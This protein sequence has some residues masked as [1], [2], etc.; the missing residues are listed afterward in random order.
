MQIFNVRVKVAKV[1]FE[2]PKLV[3]YWLVGQEVYVF[4]VVECSTS[5][6][7]LVY[8]FLIFGLY[9]IHSF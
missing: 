5:R 7:A 8:L 4:D 2:I 6:A 9:G 1:Y 3:D